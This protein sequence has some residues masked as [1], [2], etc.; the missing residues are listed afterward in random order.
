[1]QQLLVCESARLW[2]S[3]CQPWLKVFSPSEDLSS[4]FV[5]RPQPPPV[6]VLFN[7]SVAVLSVDPVACMCCFYVLHPPSLNYFLFASQ[8]SGRSCCLLVLLLVLFLSVAPLFA[9][10]AAVLSVGSVACMCHPSSATACLSIV[11][12]R[13]SF[14]LRGSC[15]FHVLPVPSHRP[16]LMENHALTV[17]LGG[18]GRDR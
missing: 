16:S 10:A 6:S 18:D 3:R 9:V 12:C 1:M 7:V 15:C 4:S 5:A 14:P 8:S 13:R 17:S 11:C 2:A